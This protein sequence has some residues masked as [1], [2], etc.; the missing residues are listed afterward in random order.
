MSIF[1]SLVFNSDLVRTKSILKTCLSIANNIN[2]T[3][4]P[5]GVNA[6]SFFKQYHTV[7]VYMKR[8]EHQVLLYLFCDSFTGKGYGPCDSL[9][10]P[11]LYWQKNS[12]LTIFFPRSS[13]C[14]RTP[15]GC[16]ELSLLSFNKA[17][18]RINHRPSWS[19]R[20]SAG[21]VPAVQSIAYTH[22][23]QDCLA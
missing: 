11:G 23:G 8:Q 22:Y 20:S 14:G 4:V 16:N 13:H 9:H 15:W 7:P 2:R 18:S 21:G 5:S 19:S 17:C 3:F 12:S 6:D 10:K 1:K